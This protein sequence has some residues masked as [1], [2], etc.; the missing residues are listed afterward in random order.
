MDG[1]DGL[2]GKLRSDCEEKYGRKAELNE[3]KEQV[4]SMTEKMEEHGDD[5]DFLKTREA[6][7]PMKT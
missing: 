6:N 1:L 2:L 3:M 5:I 7:V 4:T